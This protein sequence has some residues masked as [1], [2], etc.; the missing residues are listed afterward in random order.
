[1]YEQ[2]LHGLL[3]PYL[4]LFWRDRG[5]L[6]SDYQ[7]NVILVADLLQAV[8]PPLLDTMKMRL[9]GRLGRFFLLIEALL[10][11]HSI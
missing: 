6:R 8:S 11:G 1:M 7:F 5:L 3:F 10:S 4:L 9:T 2:L